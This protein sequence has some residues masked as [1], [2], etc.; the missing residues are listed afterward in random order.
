MVGALILLTHWPG[1]ISWLALAPLET[2]SSLSDCIPLHLKIQFNLLNI[3]AVSSS[4]LAFGKIL[5]LKYMDFQKLRWYMLL[6]SSILEE[7]WTMPLLGKESFP[8]GF[9]F[10]FFVSSNI[11]TP[12]ILYPPLF[13]SILRIQQ[14]FHNQCCLLIYWLTVDLDW[15]VK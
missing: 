6:L 5:L 7:I 4:H 11:L 8:K 14:Q 13:S 9:H 15:N 3:T 12:E 10:H 2:S 1:I